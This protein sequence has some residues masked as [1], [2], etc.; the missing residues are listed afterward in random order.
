MFF[1][2]RPLFNILYAKH[3]TDT[4]IVSLDAQRAFDQVEWGYMRSAVEAFG[5]EPVFRGWIDTIY[6]HLVAS[7]IS[8]QNVSSPFKICRGTRQGCPLSPFMFAILIEPLAVSIRQHSEMYHISTKGLSHYLILYADDILLYISN[9]QKSI[10]SNLSLIET[11]G[12]I[13]G[14]TIN[15]EK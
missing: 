14:F 1:N 8:N 15:W 10:P 11:F 4:V 6:A 3:C 5:F 2:L 9:L 7:V 13:S 12:I